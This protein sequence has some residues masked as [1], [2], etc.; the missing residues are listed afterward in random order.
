MAIQQI[1]YGWQGVLRVHCDLVV[2]LVTP[3]DAVLPHQS[4]AP[5]LAY[6]S[7]RLQPVPDR[8]PLV[9]IWANSECLAVP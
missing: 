2:T 4:L 1:R 6:G 3:A 7:E 9:G 8:S 5:R